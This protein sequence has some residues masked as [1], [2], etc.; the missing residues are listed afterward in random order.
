[1]DRFVF[2]ELH[3]YL[4]VLSAVSAKFV[5][6]LTACGI[7]LFTN[8]F[9]VWTLEVWI[10]PLILSLAFQLIPA[11]ILS[12]ALWDVHTSCYVSGS[13]YVAKF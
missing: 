13:I 12:L 8:K 2:W 10:I 11:K 4:S 6:T 7:I 9:L 1:M 5:G 3:L